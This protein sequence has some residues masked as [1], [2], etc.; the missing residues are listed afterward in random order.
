MRHTAYLEETK[1]R[2]GALPLGGEVGCD[3]CFGRGIVRLNDDA[4]HT[5]DKVPQEFH[6]HY[7]MVN[8]P[9]D[10]VGE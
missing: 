6:K 4:I 1:E 7:R 10:G 8:I 2:D 3:R 9:C 5:D